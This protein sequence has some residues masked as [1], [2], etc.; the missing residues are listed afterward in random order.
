MGTILAIANTKGGVGKSTLAV[1][2]AVTASVAGRTVL[3]VDADPQGSA[4]SFLAVRD[5]DVPAV[6]GVQITE[7]ILHRELATLSEPYDLTLVDVGGRDAPVLRSALVGADVVVVPVVPGAF[8]TWAT[9]DLFTLTDE[10]RSSKELEIVLVFNQVARTIAAR[11][12]IEHLEAYASEHGARACK[13]HLRTRTAWPRAAG[14]GLAVSEWQRT[15]KAA[16]ELGQLAKELGI[17]K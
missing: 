1:N 4:I 3:L 9:D 14:E 13:T 2:L 7:P 6:Q 15:G 5:D 17:L 8:D 12:A 16:E 11:E 10:L